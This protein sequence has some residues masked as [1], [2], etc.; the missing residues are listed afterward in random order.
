MA[1]IKPMALVENMSGKV[2]RHTNIYFRTNK[3][4]GRVYSG[5]LCNPYRGPYSANQTNMRS[6]FVNVSADVRS[7][8]AALTPIERAALEKAFKAQT[9][10]GSFYGYCFNK[11]YKEYDAEGH[12]ING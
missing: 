2:C 10:I 8:I 4:T 11:W 7:R 5:K 9:L 1:K 12:L 6:K 3:I